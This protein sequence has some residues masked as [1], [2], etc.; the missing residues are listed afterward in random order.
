MQLDAHLTS[1]KHLDRI[2]GRIS[3]KAMRYSPYYKNRRLTNMVQQ[4]LTNSFVSGGYQD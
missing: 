4:P 1:Q 2:A 3:E